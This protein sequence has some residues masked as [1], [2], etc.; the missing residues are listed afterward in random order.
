MNDRKPKKFGSLSI[1]QRLFNMQNPTEEDYKNQQE[2]EEKLRN[3]T[4]TSR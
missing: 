1:K 3:V 2:R 4:E